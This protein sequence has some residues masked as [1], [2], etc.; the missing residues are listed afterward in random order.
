MA[1]PE[2]MLPGYIAGLIVL[3][4]Y[5]AIGI[6]TIIISIK[7]AKRIW[8]GKSNKKQGGEKHD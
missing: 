6:G 8:N 1:I 4:E 2:Y 5:I 3:I 7:V